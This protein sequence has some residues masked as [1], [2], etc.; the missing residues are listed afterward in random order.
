[1]SN[2]KFRWWEKN[3]RLHLGLAFLFNELA[4]L[5]DSIAFGGIFFST[6]IVEGMQKIKWKFPQKMVPFYLE[7]KA[8]CFTRRLSYTISISHKLFS[9]FFILLS[10]YAAT[11]NPHCS[12]NLISQRTTALLFLQ[13]LGLF[14]LSVL[15]LVRVHKYMSLAGGKEILSQ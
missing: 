7:L 10:G 12:N 4:H 1:M 2:K 8:I 9:S 5:K 13:T 11:Y 3:Y 6:K 15:L 14:A